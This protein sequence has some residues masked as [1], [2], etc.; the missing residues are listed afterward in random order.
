M[1]EELFWRAFALSQSG[2]E[3]KSEL[4]PRGRFSLN[5]SSLSRSA[6]KRHST[7]TPSVAVFPFLFK[8]MSS[9][10]PILKLNR[11]EV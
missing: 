10:F 7:F 5:S 9:L 4:Q 8:E 11:D 3:G 2:W 1:E 6:Q